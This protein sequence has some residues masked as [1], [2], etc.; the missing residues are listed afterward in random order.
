MLVCMA[1]LIIVKL[2]V[3]KRLDSI[4]GAEGIAPEDEFDPGSIEKG[5][6]PESI[7]KGSDPGSTEKE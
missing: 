6:D 2:A 7:E 3:N 4:D 1:V 5:A